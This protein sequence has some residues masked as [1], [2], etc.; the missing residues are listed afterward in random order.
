MANYGIDELRF[1]KPVYV[2]D[3]IHV[4]LTVKE[5]TIKEPKEDIADH[6]VVK[7][8]VE[9]LNQHDEV[10]ANATI[11]TLVAQKAK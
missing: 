1:I 5:K 11:L 7:W 6:G 2:N 9:V 8:D 3:T 10:V 4:F